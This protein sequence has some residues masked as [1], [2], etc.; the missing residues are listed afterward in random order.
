MGYGSAEN[1]SAAFDGDDVR[2]AEIAERRGHRAGHGRE[3]S[4]VPDERGDVLE[5]NAG[6]W[7]V[8]NIAN[9]LRRTFGKIGSVGRMAHL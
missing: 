8:G 4:C 3:R 5:D 1:E 7:V 6:L 9:Q 2:D